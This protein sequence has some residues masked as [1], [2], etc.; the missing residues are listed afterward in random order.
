MQQ[1]VQK[2]HAGNLVAKHSSIKQMPLFAASSRRQLQ[3]QQLQR[4]APSHSLRTE[5]AAPPAKDV[6]SYKPMQY[7]LWQ[8]SDILTQFSPESAAII[9]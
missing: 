7:M 2:Q 1:A 3:Q 9:G 6:V 5:V 8:Q 4:A